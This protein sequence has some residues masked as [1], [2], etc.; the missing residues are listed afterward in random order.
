MSVLRRR[1][2]EVEASHANFG[3]L[4]DTIASQ[5]ISITAI[6][7]Y[8]YLSVYHAFMVIGDPSSINGADIRDKRMENILNEL[9]LTWNVRWISQVVD[10][11]YEKP[12]VLATFYNKLNDA[13]IEVK[14]VYLGERGNEVYVLDP[15][16]QGGQVLKQA[17]QPTQ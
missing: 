17:I 6:Y 4:L 5:G 13:G 2:F 15:E 1:E 8:Q 9:G 16:E 12:G 14:R 11:F 3:K 7:Y 10:Y